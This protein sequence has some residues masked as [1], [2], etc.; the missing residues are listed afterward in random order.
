MR[1]K[2]LR[3]GALIEMVERAVD[4][5]L[6]LDLNYITQI[7]A[8][9]NKILAALPGPPSAYTGDQALLKEELSRAHSTL[10]SCMHAAENLMKVSNVSA[11]VMNQAT[12]EVFLAEA[13]V[14]GDDEKPLE[15]K[16]RMA[17]EAADAEL[18]E[19]VRGLQQEYG[20]VVGNLEMV[21]EGLKV[22]TPARV[23]T[24]ARALS[25]AAVERRLTPGPASPAPQMGALERA[26]MR[27]QGGNV[28]P[29]E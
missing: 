9:I 4:A 25:P 6:E 17:D 5:G 23:A 13:R 27:N 1:Q 2:S 22:L 10:K 20:V 7:T 11:L 26:K 24:P 12:H 28:I 15:A 14:K 3:T 18:E 19:R 8:E 29:Y 16:V 21:I